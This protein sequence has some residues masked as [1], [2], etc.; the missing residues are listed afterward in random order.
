MY[1]MEE[2]ALMHNNFDPDKRMHPV[3]RSIAIYQRNF[4]QMVTHQLRAD[5]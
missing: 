1:F 4:A 3:S 2:D 5:P